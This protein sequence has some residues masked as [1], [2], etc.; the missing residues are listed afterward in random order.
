MKTLIDMHKTF[1]WAET[2]RSLLSDLNGSLKGHDRSWP[3]VIPCERQLGEWRQFP[4][5]TPLLFRFCRDVTDLVADGRHFKRVTMHT[6]GNGGITSTKVL[7]FVLVAFQRVDLVTHQQNVVRILAHT[8]HCAGKAIGPL[9]RMESTTPR[10]TNCSG[11]RDIG[12]RRASRL[13][14]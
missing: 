6:T 1:N 3:S 7:N 9:A 14:Y 10:A 8:N 13:N 12:R 5:L 11:K 2:S 4:A